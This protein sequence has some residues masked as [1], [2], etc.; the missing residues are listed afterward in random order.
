MTGDPK[1]PEEG[2]WRGRNLVESTPHHQE[3]LGTSILGVSSRNPP[4]AIG[5]H[6]KTMLIPNRLE[7]RPH[8]CVRIHYH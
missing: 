4:Q 3:G 5:E 7:T 2:L 6:L 8:V 1:D